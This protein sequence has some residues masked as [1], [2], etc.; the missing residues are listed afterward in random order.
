MIPTRFIALLFTAMFLVTLPLTGAEAPPSHPAHQQ[1][2]G[3]KDSRAVPTSP[4]ASSKPKKTVYKTYGTS[5]LPYVIR[6]AAN[7]CLVAQPSGKNTFISSTNDCGGKSKGNNGKLAIA[8]RPT[9]SRWIYM[10]WGNKYLGRPKAGG[11]LMFGSGNDFVPIPM[12]PTQSTPRGYVLL[13]LPSAGKSSKSQQCLT[14][15]PK[16]YVL[17]GTCSNSR[18]YQF[19]LPESSSKPGAKRVKAKGVKS[20]YRHPGR[21]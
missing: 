9:K 2:T 6:N 16:G 21:S 15:N 17:T 5:P 19:I 20:K 7:R 13:Q 14:I 1:A 18:E 12:Y 3:K 4:K 10:S 8:I 11:H